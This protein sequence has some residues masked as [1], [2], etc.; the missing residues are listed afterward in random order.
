MPLGFLDSSRWHCRH[1]LMKRLVVVLAAIIA[2]T[3]KASPT[4]KDVIS[5]GE[6]TY[7]ISASSLFN[8][9]ARK[10]EIIRVA[11]DFAKSKGKIAVQISLKETHPAVGAGG[12]FEYQ[13]RVV[14]AQPNS[15]KSSAIEKVDGLYLALLKL[16]ELKEKGL[17]TE[18]EFISQKAKLLADTDR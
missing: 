1:K 17:L 5:T 11:N 7:V 6:D 15:T 8:G 9:T 4:I 13:F 12:Q 14:D 2:T 16:G 10:D 3:V 18:S